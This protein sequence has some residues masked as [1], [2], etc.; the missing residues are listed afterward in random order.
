MLKRIILFFYVILLQTA[1]LKGMMSG[2]E[3]LQEPQMSACLKKIF[4]L[5]SREM[6]PVCLSDGRT[7]ATRSIVECLNRCLPPEQNVH[8]EYFGYCV[9]DILMTYAMEAILGS[10]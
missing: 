4:C 10:S 8:I 9:H 7:Y 3:R 2:M 5:T 1:L 6:M